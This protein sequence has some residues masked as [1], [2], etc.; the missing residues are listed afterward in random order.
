MSNFHIVETASNSESHCANVLHRADVLKQCFIHEETSYNP[1]DFGSRRSDI[2]VG[3]CVCVRARGCVC[4][5]VQKFSSLCPLCLYICMH[6]SISIAHRLCVCMFF[7][8]FA[9]GCRVICVCVRTDNMSV[10]VCL[11][12]QWHPG[13]RRLLPKLSELSSTC[14]L[15]S[16][17]CI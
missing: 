7:L 17:C 1:W 12:Y 11:A 2:G 3:V 5:C 14:R 13:P 4:V 16:P 15:T 8:C 9:C 10:V 6:T